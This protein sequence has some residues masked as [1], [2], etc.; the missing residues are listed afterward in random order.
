MGDLK[1]LVAPGSRAAERVQRA[2]AAQ[3][4]ELLER[5]DADRRKTEAAAIRDK[6][7]ADAAIQKKRARF[8]MGSWPQTLFGNFLGMARGMGLGRGPSG[9]TRGV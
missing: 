3:Q 9:P 1:E 8:A 2:A 4:A 7:M 6:K 5:Q